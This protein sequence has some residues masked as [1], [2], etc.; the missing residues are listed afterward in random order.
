MLRLTFALQ[1]ESNACISLCDSLRTGLLRAFQYLLL[2]LFLRL[3]YLAWNTLRGVGNLQGVFS[4]CFCPKF[5]EDFSMQNLICFLVTDFDHWWT[6][7][8]FE[9]WA[10]AK[11]SW[12]KTRVSNLEQTRLSSLVCPSFA[13]MCYVELLHRP[14]PPRRLNAHGGILAQPGSHRTRSSHGIHHTK[15]SH[16][17]YHHHRHH[18]SQGSHLARMGYPTQT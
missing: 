12:N 9:M 1:S 18:H 7:K 8:H 10:L 2:T 4:L 5:G 17:S 3:Q 6:A 15:A 16:G 14:V 11:V 13:V